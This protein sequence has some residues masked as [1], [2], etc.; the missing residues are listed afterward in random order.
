[1]IFSA[2]MKIL[3][4]GANGLVGKNF[5]E[6]ISQKNSNSKNTEITATSKD[7]K[8]LLTFIKKNQLK[9][10]KVKKLDVLKPNDCN[11]AIK[12]FDAVL[13][14][15]AN[16]DIQ[17]SLRNPKKVIDVNYNGTLNVLE[18][19]RQ[20]KVNSIIFLSTQDIYGNNIDNRE[21]ESEKITASNPYSLSKLICEETIQMYSRLYKIN[22]IILRP[23]RLYGQFQDKGI[24]PTLIERVMKCNVIEIGN[25]IKRDFLNAKDLVKAIEFLLYY[26][27]NGIFNIGTGTSTSIKEV[28]NIIAESLNKKVKIT[29]NEKLIRDPAVE[30]WGEL[31]NIDKIKKLGWKPK[32]ELKTWI[33]DNTKS[34]SKNS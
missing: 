9:N 8:S 30:R 23:S 7:T 3:I 4:T 25:N 33:Y 32:Q 21:D 20:N 11:S 19:M 27:K 15:A 26:K 28:I 22:Y 5:L 17:L 16:I 10:I 34:F 14:L 6:E 2:N 24:I 1:M 31:A 13:H 29:I 12:D 18:A